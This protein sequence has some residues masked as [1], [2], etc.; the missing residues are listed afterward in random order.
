MLTN[1]LVIAGDYVD[2]GQ[3]EENGDYRGGSVYSALGLD[4]P[5]DARLRGTFYYND[6]ELEA[7]PEFSGGTE[8]ASNFTVSASPAPMTTKRSSTSVTSGSVSP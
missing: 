1:D 3:P 4:L 6:A 7:F 8:L 5:G 2:E